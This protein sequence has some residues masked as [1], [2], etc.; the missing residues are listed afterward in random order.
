M[1]ACRDCAH[2][3][4]VTSDAGTPTGNGECRR[5]APH[6]LAGSVGDWCWPYL[7]DFAWC[8]EFAHRL[9]PTVVKV[10]GRSPA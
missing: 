5:Y 1:N 2:F 3:H 4:P 8:G 10:L 6:P 9:P 7:S